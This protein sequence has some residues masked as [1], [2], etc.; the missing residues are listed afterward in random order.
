MDD[1][2]ILFVIGRIS[3]QARKLI[4]QQLKPYNLTR[5]EWLVLACLKHNNNRTTQTF[6]KDYI[7]IDNSNL[8]KLLDKL[9]ER[10]YIEKFIDPNDRRN[11]LIQINKQ[12][13][14]KIKPIF[15][16]FTAVN[17]QIMSLLTAA[18][19]KQLS[20]WL[21]H[22]DTTLDKSYHDN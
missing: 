10:D 17:L 11:R 3:Q 15:A 7:G 22:I 14:Q 16:V 5:N 20:S 2:A 8:T 21:N 6:I 13:Q 19:Q 4:D 9:I 12:Q 1:Q 18:E